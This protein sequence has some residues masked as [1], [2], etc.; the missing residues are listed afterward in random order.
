MAGRS[1]FQCSLFSFAYFFLI[2]VLTKGNLFLFI[3]LSLKKK[4]SFPLAF[5]K[6]MFYWL[7]TFS[8]FSMESIQTLNAKWKASKSQTCISVHLKMCSWNVSLVWNLDSVA[9][10]QCS[11]SKRMIIS[12]CRSLSETER[13][14]LPYCLFFSNFSTRLPGFSPQRGISTV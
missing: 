12:V 2:L 5:H 7:M 14:T 1:F 6:P 13:K 4:K 8:P 10:W 9:R 3:L 11:L